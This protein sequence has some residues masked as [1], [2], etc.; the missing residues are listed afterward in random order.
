MEE[1]EIDRANK[2]AEEDGRG[3]MKAVAGK[4]GG[5]TRRVS[6][7]LKHQVRVTRIE[8]GSIE[9]TIEGKRNRNESITVA[10]ARIARVASY[11]FIGFIYRARERTNY[12]HRFFVASSNARLAAL[13]NVSRAA[14]FFNP[15]VPNRA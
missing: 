15:L 2:A 4:G 5:N 3:E 12:A 9:A 10:V 11:A 8:G 14:S 6:R 7:A 13:I 1:S